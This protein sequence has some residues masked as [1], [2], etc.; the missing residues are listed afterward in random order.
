[1]QELIDKSAGRVRYAA[2]CHS[3]VVEVHQHLAM[4]YQRAR[5]FRGRDDLLE[6]VRSRLQ[7]RSSSVGGEVKKNGVGVGAVKDFRQLGASSLPIVLHGRPGSGK[8]SVMAKVC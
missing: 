6:R 2:S 7:V 5:A 1:M 4:C 8:T 3:Q